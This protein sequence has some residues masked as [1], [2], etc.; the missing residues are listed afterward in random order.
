MTIASATVRN[1]YTGNGSTDTFAYTFKA[2]AAS[3][4]RVILTDTAGVETVQTIT[5]HYSVTGVGSASGGN[6]VFVTPPTDQYLV[7]I[8]SNMPRTQT[9]DLANESGFYQERIEAALD[10]AVRIAQQ[11]HG[12][13]T[14]G[15][16]TPEH[17]PA[18]IQLPAKSVRA[19]KVLGFDA[20]G[21]LYLYDPA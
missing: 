1:D 6:V 20:N 13:A 8:I 4:L 12:V 11:A 5:T 15:V 3:D 16:V 14:R 2:V 21:D 17:E 9:T 18:G 19:S 7:S 10:R